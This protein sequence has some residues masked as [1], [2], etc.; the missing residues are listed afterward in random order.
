MHRQVSRLTAVQDLLFLTHRIPYPPNKGDKIRSF[1]LLKHFAAHYRVYLG[2]F[3][4]DAQDRASISEVRAMCADAY[5]AGLQPTAACLRSLTGLLHRHPLTLCYYHDAGLQSWV[6]RLLR[7]KDLRRIVVFS[8]AMAQYVEGYASAAVRRV[9]DYVDVDSDKWRQYAESSAWPSSWIY[10][11]ESETLLAYEREVSHWC[12][13]CVFVSRPEAELFARLVPEAAERTTYVQNG[14]DTDYFSPAAEYANPY[15]AAEKILVFTGA[16]DYRANVDAA[17]WFAHE[18][19]PGI[20][21]QMPDA[22]FYIVGIRPAG[23]VRRLADLPGIRVTGAVPDVRPYL[24]HADLAVAPLRIARGIQNKVLE[25]MAMAKPVLVTRAALEG[26]DARPGE[27][28]LVAERPADMAD[29]ALAVLRGES[30]GALPT[31]AREYVI[32]HHDWSRNLSRLDELLDSL[33]SQEPIG[34]AD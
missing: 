12:D 28:L 7:E 19:F 20:K 32:R 18:V 24:A 30:V 21:A 6:S 17:C 4:D 33:A 15:P 16:M 3:I 26:I 31:A 8:S 23:R 34:F 9:I 27:D 2:T 1:H 14:V 13:A 11:R 22:R 5:F 10:R 29:R 25:A